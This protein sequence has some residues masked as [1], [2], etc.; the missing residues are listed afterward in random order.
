MRAPR[1]L[2]A[3]SGVGGAFAVMLSAAMHPA[4]CVAGR[5]APANAAVAGSRLQEPASRP[6]T[7]G[8]RCQECS[9]RSAV[10][11]PKLAETVCRMACSAATVLVTCVAALAARAAAVAAP[12]EMQGPALVLTMSLVS[13]LMRE[14]PLQISLGCLVR[15]YLQDEWRFASR[16]LREAWAPRFAVA[17]LETFVAQIG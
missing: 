15:W 12:F 16:A 8:A 5:Y 2:L 1:L 6:T 13:S 11:Q 10:R 7:L 14:T 9:S 4:M 3:R 17:T